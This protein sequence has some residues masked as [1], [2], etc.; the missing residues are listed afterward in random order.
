MRLVRANREATAHSPCPPIIG[1]N[2]KGNLDSI[3]TRPWLSAKLAKMGR[4]G[5]RSNLA[6]SHSI[7]FFKK[8]PHNPRERETIN[9]VATFEPKT[10]ESQLK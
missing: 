2:T 7:F 3:R 5:A 4:W 9:P 10:Y 6:F 1:L 8:N